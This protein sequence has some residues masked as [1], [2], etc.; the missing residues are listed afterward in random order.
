MCIRDRES[1]G[2][3]SVRHPPAHAARAQ[4]PEWHARAFVPL[5]L[6]VGGGRLATSDLQLAPLF[7]FLGA[8]AG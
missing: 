3:G 6:L 1:T 4:R 8:R 5:S 7:D 2:V